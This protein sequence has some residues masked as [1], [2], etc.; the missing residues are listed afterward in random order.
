MRSTLQRLSILIIIIRILLRFSRS[1]RLQDIVSEAYRLSCRIT[2][3]LTLL[4]LFIWFGSADF[5]D[6]GEDERRWWWDRLMRCTDGFPST[7]ELESVR[8]GAK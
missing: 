6:F 5:D 7:A 4:L 1:R 2:Q 8:G 3:A